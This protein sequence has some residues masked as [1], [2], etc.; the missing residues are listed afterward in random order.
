MALKEAR[1]FKSPKE[2]T[3]GKYEVSFSPDREK[4]I[5]LMKERRNDRA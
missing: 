1:S 4:L 2:S 5:R 3:R